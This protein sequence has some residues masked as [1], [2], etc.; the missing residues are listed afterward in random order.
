[1]GLFLSKLVRKFSTFLVSSYTKILKWR[2][3]R[4]PKSPS[5]DITVLDLRE[6]KSP[7]NESLSSSPKSGGDQE[8]EEG[9]GTVDPKRYKGDFKE[10]PPSL[11]LAPLLRS[12]IIFTK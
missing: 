11:S 1:M 6:I 9:L 7:S 5:P 8:E 10:Q 4:K 3:T 12:S 2:Q